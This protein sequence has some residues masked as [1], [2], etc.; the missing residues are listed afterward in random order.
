VAEVDGDR[1]RQF[2]LVRFREGGGEAGT[3]NPMAGVGF[4]GAPEGGADVDA[5]FET[6]AVEHR[7]RNGAVDG[8]ENVV[9]EDAC[10]E[11][12]IEDLNFRHAGP[13]G[14]VEGVR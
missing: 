6:D 2:V 9:V 7:I 5:F 4:A 10:L 14:Q 13:G 11:V 8:V 3:H 1:Q 12:K